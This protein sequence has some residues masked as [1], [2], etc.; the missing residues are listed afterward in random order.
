MPPVTLDRISVKTTIGQV[1]LSVDDQIRLGDQD[2]RRWMA[3]RI[4]WTFIAGNLLT[5]T[6]L[7]ALCWLDQ[8]NILHALIQPGQRIVDHRVVMTLIAGT[9]VQVGAIAIIIARY[10]FPGRSGSAP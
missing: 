7:G 6:A 4:V 5:V 10:L 2:L 9:T 3:T 8:A 1:H